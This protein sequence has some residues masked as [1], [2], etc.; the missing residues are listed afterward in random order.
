MPRLRIGA[1]IATRAPTVEAQHSEA[2]IALSTEQAETF[3]ADLAA[4]GQGPFIDD[5]SI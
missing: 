2:T 5:Q 1:H 3:P 4:Q